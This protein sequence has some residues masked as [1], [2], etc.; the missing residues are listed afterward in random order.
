MEVIKVDRLSKS[1]GKVEVLRDI[2]LTYCSGVIYGMVGENGAGKTTLFNCLIGLYTYDGTI[3]KAPGIKVGYLPADPFFYSLVTGMEYIEFCMKAKGCS[4]DKEKITQM[5]L[6][7]GLPLSRYASEYST[8]M[9]KKLAFMA[10]LLQEND[11]YIL[12][13]PFNGVDLKGCIELKKS[14]R[15][16]KAAGRT[17]L[18]SSHLIAILHELC[19]CID[20]LDNHTLIKRYVDEDIAAIERDIL[21]R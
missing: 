14:I 6:V 18:I 13:E 5:N 1:F 17:V 11:L 3:E 7:F 4:P 8:G 9:K 10:L 16:L 12:D 20:Y 2:S 15:S 19:D 21:E